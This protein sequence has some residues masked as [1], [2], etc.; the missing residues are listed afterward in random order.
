MFCPRAS[1]VIASLLAISVAARPSEKRSGGWGGSWSGGA[2]SHPGFS[3]PASSFGEF[4]KRWGLDA[5]SCDMA[6][7]VN[8]MNLAAGK[9]FDIEIIKQR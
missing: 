6:A 4:G 5:G 8:N 2:S 1:V 7:A 3:A 9:S